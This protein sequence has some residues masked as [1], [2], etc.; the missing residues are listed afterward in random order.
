MKKTCLLY[1]HHN[2]FVPHHALGHMMYSFM[3]L[4]PM[5]QKVPNKPSNCWKAHCT[6]SFHDG[7]IYIY[8]YIQS[9]TYI[10]YIFMHIYMYIYVYIFIIL[11]LW[12][13]TTLSVVDYIWPFLLHS[14]LGFLSTLWLIGT[15]SVWTYIMQPNK[16][17][18]REP[19]WL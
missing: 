17:V 8:I 2:C 16:W 15:S 10:Y 6:Q 1:H 3:L 18:A 11:L 14:F 13:M 5:N 12:E 9:I 19:L 7:D 4:V